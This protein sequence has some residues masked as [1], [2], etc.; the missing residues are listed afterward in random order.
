[1]PT[2][3]MIARHFDLIARDNAVNSANANAIRNA[4]IARAAQ[5][6]SLKNAAIATVQCARW[7]ALEQILFELAERYPHDPLFAKTGETNDRTAPKER[8]VNIMAFHRRASLLVDKILT[9]D[10][11]KKVPSTLAWMRR[12]AGF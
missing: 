10:A 3:S 12:E 7:L 1:M 5:D 6:Q 8:R 2:P 9:G 4:N 11:N